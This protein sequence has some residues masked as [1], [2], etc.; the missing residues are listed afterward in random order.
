[1]ELVMITSLY[2]NKG[3]HKNVYKYC[4][5][6]EKHPYIV[7]QTYFPYAKISDYVPWKELH[8]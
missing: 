1:M 6:Q 3:L 5:Q 8:S 4:S 2:P 7:L